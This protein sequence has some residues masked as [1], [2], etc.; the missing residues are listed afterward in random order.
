MAYQYTDYSGYGNE[1]EEETRRRRAMMLA[2]LP[3]GAGFGDIASQALTNRMGQAQ[4][5]MT[6]AGQMVTNPEEEL[7]KRMGMTQQA[8]GP[9]APGP[10]E[11]QTQVPQQL[12]QQ[13]AISPE[14]AQQAI[15]QPRLPQP[16]PAVQV[17]GPA[18]MPQ[19]QP[20]ASA[21]QYPVA[22][23]TIPDRPQAQPQMQARPQIQPSQAYTPTV[24]RQTEPLSFEQQ[25]NESLIA[26]RNETDPAKRRNMFAQLMAR[27]DVS[28][29]NKV[30]ANRLIAEDYMKQKAVSD[31]EQ[32]IAQATPNDLSRYMKERT[33]EGS[34]VKA[35]LYARL[36][37]NDLAQK[38]QELLSPT[39]KMGG[40]IDDQGNR[41]TV[42]RDNK[43]AI[44][45]G[46][47]ASGRTINQETLSRLSAAGVTD[48]GF[49]VDAGTYMDPTGKV[50]GNWV[51]ERR[52]GGTMFRQVGTGAIASPEQAGAL[53][54]VGVGGTLSDQRTRM[55]QEINLK[56]Q[57]KTAE[58]KMAILRPYNQQLVGAGERAISPEEV[59]ISAPQIQAPAQQ[60]Q[61]MAQ[62]QP[63]PAQQAPAQ[64]MPAQQAQPAAGPAPAVTASTLPD[65]GIKLGPRPTLGSIEAD[66]EKAKQAAQEQG[67]D[68]GKLKV[69]QPKA[70]N[71]ADSLITQITRLVEHP[72]F[73]TSVGRKGL[74][75]GFGLMTEPPAGTDAADFQ[76]RL[77]E[78]SGQTFLQAIE[79]LRGMGA[80]SNIEGETATKAVQRMATSQSEK[81]FKLAAKEFQ[82]TIKRGIDTTRG[83]LGQV[84]KYE[85]PPASQIRR[86]TI[87]GKNYIHDGKGWREE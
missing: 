58:E 5:T 8:A 14:M 20:Q 15:P 83:K 47:D 45:R 27:E 50:G 9:V 87:N 22:S 3:E 13:G 40:A 37:L 64:Q 35:I 7:R 12:P 32:K 62:A 76:A 19:A 53:R 28:E 46:F 66:K 82:D 54:K 72:G 75:Y 29:G 71:T 55:I 24:E 10:L 4:N 33:K 78:I 42:E 74:S 80:L 31:A 57:G 63:A 2:G 49:D 6:Q 1:T 81:E 86:K 30:L 21:S 70:E 25:T 61:P 60:A 59:G 79:T 84:P 38:E 51:L 43:G 18:Q 56:L 73:E 69:N 34:W 77:K 36:G 52:P 39:L 68:L 17:A 44:V 65:G 67:I 16:G 41:Y 11:T 48:K 85:T 23:V 26:A